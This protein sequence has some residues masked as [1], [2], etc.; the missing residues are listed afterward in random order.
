MIHSCWQRFLARKR[1]EED[2]GGKVKAVAAEPFVTSTPVNGVRHDT[3]LVFDFFRRDFS[4]HTFLPRSTFLGWY[5]TIFWKEMSNRQSNRIDNRSINYTWSK[6]RNTYI[7][8]YIS[9]DI[10]GFWIASDPLSKRAWQTRTVARC[11]A[12]GYE[13]IAA[14]AVTRGRTPWTITSRMRRHCGRRPRPFCTVS[15]SRFGTLPSI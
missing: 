1:G 4:S 12:S 11:R 3:W 15:H 9:G 5:I 8:A 7:Y 6:R 10:K 2:G 13:Q 14:V